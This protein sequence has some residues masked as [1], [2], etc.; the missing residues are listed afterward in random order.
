[1]ME[2]FGHR[3]PLRLSALGFVGRLNYLGAALPFSVLRS[4]F[5]L[6]TV[7]AGFFLTLCLQSGVVR[8]LSGNWGWRGLVL[9]LN[10]ESLGRVKRKGS[11]SRF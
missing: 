4:G 3:R 5:A 8:R 9:L 2:V 6:A 11:V 1:M 7:A 10:A